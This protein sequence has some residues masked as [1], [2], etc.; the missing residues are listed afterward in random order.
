MDSLTGGQLQALR[1]LAEKHGGAATGFLNIADAQ[2]L[3]EL[4]FASR[5]RQ[6]WEITPAGLTRLGLAGP[7]EQAEGGTV[8]ELRPADYE[9]DASA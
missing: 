8:T 7:P 5:T 6:G 1:N 2:R 4:G 3:T 9:D